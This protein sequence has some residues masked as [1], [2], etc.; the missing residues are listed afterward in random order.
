[1]AVRGR[2]PSGSW[3][4]VLFT[5]ARGCLLKCDGVPVNFPVKNGLAVYTC[6]RINATWF[7]HLAHV[8]DTGQ[9]E[10]AREATGSGLPSRSSPLRLP[11][12]ACPLFVDESARAMVQH[13]STQAGT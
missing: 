3:S 11:L 7:C 13:S 2:P 5:N 1:M 4:G 10:N 9:F 8:P 12:D 6:T